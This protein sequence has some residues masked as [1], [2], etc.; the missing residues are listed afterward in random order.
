LNDYKIDKFQEL[1]ENEEDISKVN[2]NMN[3][4]EEDED[5]ED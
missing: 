2:N 5:V 3:D 1:S 4:G